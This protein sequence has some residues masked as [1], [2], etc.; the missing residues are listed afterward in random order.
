MKKRIKGMVS[1]FIAASMGITLLT[2]CGVKKISDVTGQ[3]IEIAAWL[4]YADLDHTSG[5]EEPK[6]QVILS[7]LSTDGES[8]ATNSPTFIGDFDK[9]I[10]LFEGDL[11]KVEVISGTSKNGRQFV[12]CK[13]AD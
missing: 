6:E 9:M 8:F 2:G 10:S 5:E 3:V 1:I 11:Q 13:Y 7:L 12:T 4:K